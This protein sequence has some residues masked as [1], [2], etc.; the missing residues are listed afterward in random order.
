M[1]IKIILFLLLLATP[2]QAW[3][4]P[5]GSPLALGDHPRLGFISDS[6]RASHPSAV[7]FTV[8]EMKTKLSETTPYD[9]QALFQSYIDYLD[10]A[11][12]YD[13]T[14]ETRMIA[15][16]TNPDPTTGLMP[17]RGREYVTYDA[18]GYAFLAM[19]DPQN[20]SGIS[21]QHT[22]AEY[23]AKAIAHAV[24]LAT[25]AEAANMADG[26]EAWI[27]NDRYITDYKGEAWIGEGPVNMTLAVVADWLNADLTQ[28][29]KELF[30]DAFT[31]LNP[32]PTTFEVFASAKHFG[33]GQNGCGIIGLYGDT[34]GPSYDDKVADLMQTVE[35]NWLLSFKDLS[36]KLFGQGLSNAVEGPNYNMFIGNHSLPF[37][38]LFATALN[39]NLTQTI[40]FYKGYT[41]Y[42]LYTLL[43]QK[44]L[45]DT[46]VLST[47]DGGTNSNAKLQY[48]NKQSIW[49]TIIHDSEANTASLARWLFENRYNIEYSERLHEFAIL[50]YFFKGYK[51]SVIAKSPSELNYPL[52]K[53]IGAG[54]YV[55]RTGFENEGD[56]MISFMA[57]KYHL[58]SYHAHVDFG[59][60][61]IFKNGIIAPDRQIS[62]SYTTNVED[63][64]K[65]MFYNTMGV[66][67]DSETLN[68]KNFMGYRTNLPTE[69]Y[70]SSSVYAEH[71]TAHVGT[72]KNEDLEMVHYDY[73]DYDYS[74]SWDDAKV[75]YAEREFV[76]LRTEGGTNDEY[77]VVYDRI[78]SVDAADRKFFLLHAN[79]EPALLDNFNSQIVMLPQDYP[80]D[81]DSGGGR[82]VNLSSSPS[83]DNIVRITNNYDVHHGVLFNKT[84]FPD[85]FQINK[86]GG[87]GHQWET[88][89][90][91]LLS[92][93]S[94]TS[95]YFQN[96]YASWAIQIQSNTNQQYDTFLNVM[97][98]GDSDTLTAMSETVP[99][100]TINMLGAHIK[101]N[102]M[103]RVVLFSR[104]KNMDVIDTSI[105]YSVSPTSSSTKHLLF[106]L[107]PTTNYEIILNGDSQNFTSNSAGVISFDS[108][109]LA[110]PSILN[111]LI[112]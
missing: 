107:Q 108:G 92:G 86:V 93:S 22:I 83:Q 73:I 49:D 45:G 65:N 109:D 25:G 27:W 33:G 56:T 7:G 68:D 70:P 41:D 67:K 102:T 20:M 19:L 97:Q 87:P 62:K 59:Q 80:N 38:N 3:N 60:F 94:D 105:N 35:N 54:Q 76:Y 100:E 110:A 104:A 28:A 74:N 32:D 8:S 58:N 66:M 44:V 63:T 36:A 39:E 42:S 51:N 24:Y 14:S 21:A 71:G 16:A 82:W 12:A 43:P 10:S 37:I 99:I 6:Y 15:G 17:A 88:A 53:N 13:P 46:A 1:K 101:D 26:D 34:L 95:E 103:N 90:G 52:S 31:N 2:A 79:F 84:L 30:V 48:G 77:V 61:R 9:Y 89:N 57:P 81:P 85:N 96:R 72:V 78:S 50:N 111:I 18:I 11:E 75:D 69:R 91:K 5:V 4:P 64:K 47:D 112:Q 55:M 106:G 40:S 23:K 98:V 29:Q